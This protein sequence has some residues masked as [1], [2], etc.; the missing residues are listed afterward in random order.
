MALFTAQ[1]GLPLVGLCL[2]GHSSLN[3]IAWCSLVRRK[4]GELEITGSNPVAVT[5]IHGCSV[6]AH[7]VRGEEIPGST[8]GWVTHGATSQLAMA[9]VS[10]TVEPKSLAGSTPAR[11]AF[12]SF[13]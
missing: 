4:L 5:F 13:S 6:A 7:L 8:P 9:P 11:S 3:N 2:V 10:K 1:A 12:A